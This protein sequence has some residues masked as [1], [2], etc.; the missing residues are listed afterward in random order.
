[1]VAVQQ[2]DTGGQHVGDVLR[3]AD[4]DGACAAHIVVLKGLGNVPQIIHRLGRFQTA[5]FKPVGAD[6]DDR[7]IVI[8]GNRQNDRIEFAVHIAVGHHDAAVGIQLGLQLVGG[9]GLKH[10]GEISQ[11]VRVGQIRKLRSRDTHH[12][13]QIIG[14]DCHVDL[15]FQ[16]GSRTAELIGDIDAVFRKQI[17]PDVAVHGLRRFDVADVVFIHGCGNFNRGVVFAERVNIGSR[18]FVCIVGSVSRFLRGR[19]IGRVRCSRLILGCTG[20]CAQHKQH[21]EQQAYEF[22]HLCFLHSFFA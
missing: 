18:S 8:V 9:I 21:S 1:M 13:G 12:I 6:G 14:G 22:F 2:A 15:R 10:I 4:A 19:L 16:I 20:A 3:H 5:L 17:V 11:H 7:N